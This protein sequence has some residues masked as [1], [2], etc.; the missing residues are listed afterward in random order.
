MASEYLF[1]L[2]Y[3]A[4]KRYLKKLT[5]DCETACILAACGIPKNLWLDDVTIWANL[6]FGDVYSNLID[7]KGSFTI[8]KLKAYK[9][10]QA[11][12][13]SIMDECKQFITA[14]AA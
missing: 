12:K 1:T 4:Q 9:S 13:Y 6:E 7:T 14:G 2:D 3:E 11:N 5:I 10:L 8:D